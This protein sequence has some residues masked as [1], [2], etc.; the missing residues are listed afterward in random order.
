VGVVRDGRWIL[1]G[2]DW[3]VRSG[4]RWVVLGPNGSGKTTLL[5]ILSTYLYPSAGTVTVLGERHGHTD[6]RLLRRRIGYAS[7]HLARMLDNR[8]TALEAVVTARTAALHPG[9]DQFASADVRRARSL[10]RS[11]GSEQFAG[12][13]LG[14][15]SE[16]ERQRVQIARALMSRPEL[17]LLDEVSAGLDLGARERLVRRLTA[18]AADPASPVIVFVTHHVEEIP[19]HFTHALL[20]REGRPFALGPID[21]ALTEA[22]LSGCFGLPITL[23]RR[24]GRFVA[25]GVDRR[26]DRD[27]GRRV[28]V[29]PDGRAKALRPIPPPRRIAALDAGLDALVAGE[30]FEAHELL[31]PAWMGTRDPVERDLY[32][33]LI[34][35][36]AAGVH[37]WRRNPEGVR[38]NLE[39]ARLRLAAVASDPALPGAAA[40]S[41]PRG[42]RRS[43]ATLGAALARVDVAAT[44]RWVEAALSRPSGL[45][46]PRDFGRAIRP[47]G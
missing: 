9:W 32:Q 37:A 30:Y 8:L 45:P 43:P 4:E 31:E 42:R 11:V 22:S 24:G 38:K 36:A 14:T 46:G 47:G 5:E 33:G 17:L 39:G 16:G 7:A 29:G 35:L 44:L 1:S 3:T 19:R 18:L 25:R 41:D 13:T 20:L 12:H 6:V 10:L 26:S 40:P 27:L 34:K 23:E 28:V 15:L 21:E 2:V